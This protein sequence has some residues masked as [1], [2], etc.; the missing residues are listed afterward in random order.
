MS[1]ATLVPIALWTVRS[2]LGLVLLLPLYVA[3]GMVYPFTT[4]KAFAFQIIVEVLLPPWVLL[5]AISPA[6]RPRPSPLTI[7]VAAFVAIVALAD[8]TGVNPAHS[9]WSSFVRMDGLNGLL[10]V[11]VFF[12]M[13]RS[14]VTTDT[15]WRRYFAASSAVSVIVAVLAIGDRLASPTERGGATFGNPLPLGAYLLCHLFIVTFLLCRE[16]RRGRR[17]VLAAAAVLQAVAL[18]ATGGRGVLL[19]LFVAAAG[20]VAVTAFRRGLRGPE[21][22][23]RNLAVAAVV[24]AIAATTALF[25]ARAAGFI[26]DSAPL[27]YAFDR[28]SLG[29]RLFLWDTAWEGIKERP[30]LGWGQEN[31]Y[32]VY[33]RRHDPSG[34]ADYPWADRTHNVLLEW[35]FAAG[36]PGLLAYLALFV[37]AARGLRGAARAGRLSA[38]EATMLGGLLA[39]YLLQNL[40]AFDTLQTYVVFFSVLAFLDHVAAPESRPIADAQMVPA[41]GGGFAFAALAC[42]VS[43]VALY[44]LNGRPMRGAREIGVAVEAWDGRRPIAEVHAHFENALRQGTLSR[45]EAAEWMASVVPEALGTRGIGTREERAALVRATVAALTRATDV[46]AVDPKHLFML[47]AVARS[48][49]ALDPAYGAV[50]TAALTRAVALGQRNPGFAYELALAHLA[51]GA[52][53][54]AVASMQAVLARVPAHKASLAALAAVAVRAGRPDVADE[55]VRRAR[56]LDPELGGLRLMAESVADAGDRGRARALIDEIITRRPHDAEAHRYRAILLRSMGETEAAMAAA[57]TAAELDPSVKKGADEFVR[58]LNR[59]R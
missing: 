3:P 39:G 30:L 46:A 24:I 57:R 32:V 14:V 21:R 58:G 27:S 41:L 19:A 54:E 13:L 42:L 35:L 10:H 9:F 40:L 47:G 29:I 8:V 53:E 11:L 59:A 17:G 34:W 15:G 7:S 22:L 31:F 37:A 23:V 48:A 18:V 36:V 49:I 25:A 52:G 43:L 33:G 50:S 2:G 5:L 51:R 26:P 45:V 20:V 12:A 44:E 28:R 4:G 38:L 55:A 56:A 6:H 16:E 1:V